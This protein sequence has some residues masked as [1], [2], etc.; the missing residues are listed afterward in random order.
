RTTPAMRRIAAATG[1]STFLIRRAGCDSLCLHREFGDYP[2]QVVSVI[3]GGRQ[4]L[5]V[6]AAGL[7]LLSALPNDGVDEVLRHNAAL[8]HAYGN[9]SLQTMRH[10]VRS[11]R[12][13]GY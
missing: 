2:I 11:T 4:P 3:V 10:L 5:G 9:I 13:R 6:G 8:L 12:A 1:N 7:A